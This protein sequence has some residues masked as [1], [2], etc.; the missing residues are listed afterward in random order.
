[1]A[2]IVCSNL[3]RSA[4]FYGGVLGLKQ[5]GEA[6]VQRVEFD[7]GNGVILSLYAAGPGFS[8]RAGSLQLAF[9]VPNVDALVNDARLAGA[10]ILQEPFEEPHARVA[11]IADPDGYPVQVGTR[12][13]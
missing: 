4:A 9:R 5:R 6:S 11:V 10:E 8:V 1:M 12:T 3:Q 2:M 13:S 7:L